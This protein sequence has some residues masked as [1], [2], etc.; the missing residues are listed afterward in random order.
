MVAS[1][2]AWAGEQAAATGPAGSGI[3]YVCPM[4]PQVQANAAGTCPI[5][6][7]QLVRAD[8]HAEPKSAPEQ[9][10]RQMDHLTEHYLALQQFLASDDAAKLAPHALGVAAAAEELLKAV[11][12]AKID[13]ADAMASAARRLRSAVV[14]M[15]GQQITEDRV[16]FV[17]VSAAMIELLQHVRPDPERWPRL[18]I[19]HCPMSKGDWAQGSSEIRNPYYG[20]SMLKCGEL[21][22]TE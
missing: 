19:F 6:A 14:K 16:Q 10:R 3:A 22:S 21:K 20:F 18:Y 12:A 2:P 11:Q 7:M 8:Q 1:R 9:V 17:E 4:H 5:C 15:N 13:H